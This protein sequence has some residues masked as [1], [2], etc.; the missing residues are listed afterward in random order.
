MTRE[1]VVLTKIKELLPAVPAN[2]NLE[3]V[4]NNVIARGRTPLDICCKQEIERMQVV[5]KTLRSTLEDLELAI[6]G[7]IVMNDQLYNSMNSIYDGRVPGHWLKISWPGATLREWF[8]Q[9]SLRYNQYVKWN[10][11]GKVDAF[12][13]G[14]M[15]NPAGFLT[16]LRQNMCRTEGW[17]LDETI[18][19]SEVLSGNRNQNNDKEP[20]GSVIIRGIFLEGAKWGKS[21]NGN[22]AQWGLTELAPA[23][24][25]GKGGKPVTD[26]R[27]EMPPIRIWP[28]NKKGNKE[29]V[30]KTDSDVY[31]CPVYS[32]P[33]RTDLNYVFD[34]PLV[35]L[36]RSTT[37]AK[38]WVLRG[39]CLTT[40]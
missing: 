2:F 28:A 18:M 37:K 29:Q 8:E 38:H 30:F 3:A 19:M 23:S 14:G 24:G 15:F 4:R 7:T 1:D 12:W 27:M 16:S 10:E 20:K 11:T 34:I 25:K 40:I 36:N 13:L 9:V 39:V 31:V 33:S 21:G 22:Q 26:L 17:S 32:S 35:S 6:A 5:L